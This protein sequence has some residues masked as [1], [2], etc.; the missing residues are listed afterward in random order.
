MAALTIALLALAPIA[1][2]AQQP[3][4]TG[5]WTNT[6]L[7]ALERPAE[8]AGKAFFTEKEAADY[9][10]RVK[11]AV[12]YDTRDPDPE[13][14]V[15]HSYNELFRERGGVVPT[16]RTSLIVDP[17]DGRLPPLTPEGQ[18]KAAA[19]AADRRKR[20]A[21]PA[22]SW[23]DRNLAERCITRGAPKIPGGY[24]NN[25]QILQTP[26]YVV[27]LQE[28]I[29]EA[30][31]IPLDRKT[32]PDPSVH[33]WMGDSIG[34]WEGKTLVVETTNFDDRIDH[35]SFDC[36][37]LAGEHLRVTERFTRVSPDRSITST[38]QTIP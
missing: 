11:A 25:F 31:I 20:G 12:D 4:L 5:Y 17:P 8:L 16:L 15:N 27:I 7:T 2:R 34:H 36:C 23:E 14:D 21:D 13:K 22:D 30:R 24:N 26:G 38:P 32:H 19:R 37:G 35:N 18:K 1:V 29:H 33:L 10:K 3:D 6:T 28:M 9:E